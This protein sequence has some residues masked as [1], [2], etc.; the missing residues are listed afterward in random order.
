[1][2]GVAGVATNRLLVREPSRVASTA[3]NAALLFLLV[4]T[5]LY[6]SITPSPTYKMAEISFSL[7]M[8]AGRFSFARRVVTPVRL[9]IRFSCI[10]AA[11][12]LSCVS[13]LKRR[14]SA[15]RRFSSAATRS[16]CSMVLTISEVKWRLTEVSR[17]SL[18][19]S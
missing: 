6:H 2:A 12:R 3:S 19:M 8:G 13:W 15:R 17:I 16:L 4:T 5:H 1:M 14:M 11:G 9:S 7:T 10:I 18:D